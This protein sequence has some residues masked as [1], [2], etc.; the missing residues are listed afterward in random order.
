MAIKDNTTLQSLFVGEDG[1]GL[2]IR[3]L[4]DEKNVISQPKYEISTKGVYEEFFRLKND[5]DRAQVF[6]T[7]QR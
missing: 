4:V 3:N 7:M 1:Y 6:Q 5:A 2:K